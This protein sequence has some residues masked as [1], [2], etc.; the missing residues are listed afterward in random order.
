MF[1]RDTVT[2]FNQQR[3]KDGSITWYPTVLEGVDLHEDRAAIVRQYG[4]QC[5]DKALLHVKYGDGLT[6]GG[7]PYLEPKA[8]QA[9]ADPATAVTFASGEAFSFFVAG[10]WP[11]TE[12]ID[13]D[14]Y[15]GGLYEHLCRTRD[16]VY[17][18]R[19]VSKYDLIPHFEVTGR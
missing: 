18:V 1:Y 14:A 7:K 8:W 3:A 13:D 10:R 5:D 12:P 19:S 9:E 15:A 4:E 6:V 11:D 2:L 16:R 17:A